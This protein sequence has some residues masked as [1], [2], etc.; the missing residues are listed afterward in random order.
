MTLVGL[1][2]NPLQALNFLE[3]AYELKSEAWTLIV[4][5]L[6]GP[7]STQLRTL[8]Q[9]HSPEKLVW[10]PRSA[11]RIGSK[12]N[13][14]R[15]KLV[16]TTIRKLRPR[17]LA[18]GQYE[19]RNPLLTVAVGS[20]PSAKVFLLDEGTHTLLL[21]KKLTKSHSLPWDQRVKSLFSR[22]LV[23]ASLKAPK[24]PTFFTVFHRSVPDDMRLQRNEYNR[25]KTMLK[26]KEECENVYLLGTMYHHFFSVEIYQSLLSDAVKKLETKG[27]LVYVPHRWEQLDPLLQFFSDSHILV[28]HNVMPFE[29]Y[30]TTQVGAPR[31]V[32]AFFSSALFN[33]APLLS[34]FD[35]EI[36]CLKTP[37][38]LFRTEKDANLVET[39]VS[40]LTANPSILLHEISSNGQVPEKGDDASQNV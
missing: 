5:E 10:L 19:P 18:L 16:S 21:L 17:H 4:N 26:S 31:A 9:D 40:S 6:V 30:L 23:G 24:D 11:Q 32:A 13:I 35:T 7:D 25:L 22:M 27:K 8:L 28:E 33:L 39:I 15:Q 12:E 38:A 36:I 29:W 14:E 20:A 1:I 34:D 3:L 2:S 37:R